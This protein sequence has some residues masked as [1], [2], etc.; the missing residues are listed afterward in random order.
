M[1]CF[2]TLTT[3]L[4]IQINIFASTK[5]SIINTGH[6]ES[7]D[8][9]ARECGDFERRIFNHAA[10][11]ITHKNKTI[12]F[13]T[14]IGKNIDAEF[15]E[16]MPFWAKPFFNY[17]YIAS[18][19]EQLPY[20]KYDYIFLSHAHWD[21]TGGLN[22]NLNGPIML[23]K[24][25]KDEISDKHR[26]AHRTFKTHIDKKRFHEFQWKHEKYLN[27]DKYYAPF[28]DKSVVFVHLPGHSM[29]SIGLILNS[30]KEK[31]FFVGDA[32]WTEEQLNKEQHKFYLSSQIVDR[33]RKQVLESMKKIKYMRDQLNYKIIPTH[34]EVV[35]RQFG[36]YPKWKELN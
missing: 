23:P 12:L 27:F 26:V 34:D 35:Q 31:F 4:I 17:T 20:Q 13:D 32:V 3:L 18:V 25:E 5:F 19:K 6:A 30:N 16:S 29:G 14:G 15:E 28:N 7:Y 36:Y 1:K 2:F 22:E 11:I 21:H 8:F 10:I 33:D 9:L 24:E